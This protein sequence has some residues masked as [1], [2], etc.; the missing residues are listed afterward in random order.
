MPSSAHLEFQSHH[1][2]LSSC[3]LPVLMHSSVGVQLAETVF[4]QKRRGQPSV[5]RSLGFHVDSS[6]YAWH[7]LAI[8]QS[9]GQIVDGRPWPD[10]SA[11]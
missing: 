5:L 7:K 9:G 6:E 2:G 4:R 11:S 8:G 1:F 3:A 10:Q